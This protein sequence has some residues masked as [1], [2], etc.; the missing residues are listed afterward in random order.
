MLQPGIRKDRPTVRFA[1]HAIPITNT[2]G[3]TAPT[4]LPL[5][6]QISNQFKMATDVPRGD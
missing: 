5:I 4:R 1:A 2:A 6:R 3:E